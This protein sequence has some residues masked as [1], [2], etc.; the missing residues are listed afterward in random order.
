[1]ADFGWKFCGILCFHSLSFVCVSRSS[2][3]MEPF[4]RSGNFE[5]LRHALFRS[6]FTEMERKHEL[7]KK[8]PCLKEKKDLQMCFP[9]SLRLTMF[10]AFDPYLGYTTFFRQLD[11]PWIWGGFDFSMVAFAVN[12]RF[13][14][15]S[16]ICCSRHTRNFRSCFASV[17]PVV[18]SDCT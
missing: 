18:T 14:P 15:L 16:G 11:L 7:L 2:A 13:I 6:Y 9:F 10:L 5:V 17:F 1:M 3:E 4:R 8:L 12:F